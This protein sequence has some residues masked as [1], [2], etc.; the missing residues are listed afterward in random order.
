MVTLQPPKG[1]SKKTK[2]KFKPEH[3]SKYGLVVTAAGQGNVACR[4]CKVFGEKHSLPPLG[5]HFKK[6]SPP[7]TEKMRCECQS[8][9]PS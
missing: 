4:F 3:A 8:A 6:P 5:C 1:K 9:N 7:I 2:V